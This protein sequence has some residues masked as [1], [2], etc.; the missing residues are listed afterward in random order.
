DP[1]NITAGDTLWIPLPCSCDM[2]D[3]NSVMHYAHIV[4]SGSSIEAIAQEYG[5]TQQSLLTINGIKDPKSLLAG[6]LLDVPLPG[7]SDI[8]YLIRKHTQVKEAALAAGGYPL[9]FVK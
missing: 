6:Q 4:E 5:T 1:D 8:S 3:G 9:F 7:S 2:V